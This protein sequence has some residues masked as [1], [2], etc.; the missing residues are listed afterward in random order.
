MYLE[1]AVETERKCCKY[2]GFEITVNHYEYDIYGL[3]FDYFIA[4]IERPGIYHEYENPSWI[5]RPT[6]RF[7]NFN[8]RS[9]KLTIAWV[10]NQCKSEIDKITDKEKREE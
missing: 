9:K 8:N 7:M 2:K 3:E 6:N 4:Q 1:A 10:L 5:R